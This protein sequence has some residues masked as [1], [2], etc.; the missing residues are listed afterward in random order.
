ML[1]VQEQGGPVAIEMTRAT[2]IVPPYDEI[3]IKNVSDAW[4]TQLRQDGSHCIFGGPD[5]RQYRWK[6]SNAFSLGGN[7]QV[8]ARCYI[9]K[10][11]LA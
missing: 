10:C 3:L 6:W 5:G 11:V 1:Y 9:T 8:N 7:L 4:T 2:G